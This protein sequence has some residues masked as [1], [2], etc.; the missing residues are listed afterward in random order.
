[1]I[2][3]SDISLGLI[4][5]FLAL[6]IIGA[7][8]D[9]R[10][11]PTRGASDDP[12]YSKAIEKWRAERLEEING[13]DGWTTLVGLFWLNEGQN[14][15]GSDP[16]NEIV[17]PRSSAPKL[18]GSMRLDNG[19]VTLEARPDAGITS[20]GNAAST[21]VLRSDGDGKPT[22]LKLGSLKLFVIK[23]GEKLGLRVKDQQNPARSHFAGLDYFPLDLKWRLDAKFEPC[24]PPKIIPIVNVLGMVDNMTSPGALVFE[25]NGKTY[26]L[27]PVLEKGSK[28]LFIIFGD[29][30]TGKE[31]YGAGRYL[32]ADPPGP[33]GN[34]VVDFN[35]AHNPSCAFTKFATCPL[36]PRQNRLAIRVEAGEKKYAGSGH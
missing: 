13:E 12:S 7:A 31:T 16:S 36:P 18:A 17:L 34:V 24:D 1:M 21:L 22:V 5:I 15:F 20:D 33:D 27:D 29:K 2:A 25:V 28:Q 9:D 4:I 10:T 11:K 6:F 19:V 30:T 26:R 14:K 3:R 35:K 23:R 32:Y 8:A